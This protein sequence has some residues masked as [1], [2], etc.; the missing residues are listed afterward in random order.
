M[1]VQNGKV[2]RKPGIEAW[3]INQADVAK[4]NQLYQDII[5]TSERQNWTI[6]PAQTIQLRKTAS[7]MA[8]YDATTTSKGQWVMRSIRSGIDKVAKDTIPGLRELDANFVDQL[9][10]LEDGLRDL[11]YKGGDVKWDYRSNIGSIISNLA[12]PSRAKLLGRLEEILPGIGKKVEAVNNLSRLYKAMNDKGIFQK[13]SGAG[14]AGA[15]FVFGW[16]VFPIIGNILWAV[17]GWITWLLIDGAVTKGKLSVLE[18]ILKKETPQKRAE[19]WRIVDA[20]KKNKKLDEASKK[21]VDDIKQKVTDAKVEEIITE[22]PGP[23][24]LGPW[25]EK[26]TGKKNFNVGKMSVEKP[27][28]ESTKKAVIKDPRVKAMNDYRS[29]ISWRITHKMRW[30]LK[31]TSS[32]SIQ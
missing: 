28:L 11:V 21:I 15:W 27:P 26:T 32:Q 22:K 18:N 23:L 4:F 5:A 7:S 2:I 16:T 1:E 9:T 19:I 20:I 30:I 29:Q 17:A 31:S 8:G 13:Y 14:G 6:T 12:N 3:E 25:T 10:R 24:K